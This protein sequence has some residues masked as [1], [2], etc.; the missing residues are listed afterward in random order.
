MGNTK[1]R[2]TYSIVVANSYT[3]VYSIAATKLPKQPTDPVS[4]VNIGYKTMCLHR[5]PEVGVGINKKRT[6]KTR[7]HEVRWPRGVEHQRGGV[8]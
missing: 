1:T 8:K 6:E 2:E 5:N 4:D 7:H 3:V